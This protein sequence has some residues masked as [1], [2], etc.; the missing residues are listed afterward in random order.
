MRI[1]RPVN[2]L[3][4][5]SITP[6]HLRALYLSNI[7]KPNL[8]PQHRKAAT[9]NLRQNLNLPL[10]LLVISLNP[11]LNLTLITPVTNQTISI[12]NLMQLRARRLRV[13]R[14]RHE[15]LNR[16][17]YLALQN[18]LAEI[19]L[20][21]QGPPN[22]NPITSAALKRSHHPASSTESTGNVHLSLLKMR[23]DHLRK[24]NKVA[25]AL[26][27]ALLLVLKSPALERATGQIDEIDARFLELDAQVLTVL[28][29]CAAGLELDAVD[30]DAD[31][32]ARVGHAALYLGDDLEDYAAAVCKVAA[33]FVGAFVGC[34]GEELGQ[35]VAVGAVDLW[36][37]K[38]NR[39]LERLIDVPGHRRNQLDGTDMPSRPTP[40]RPS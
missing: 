24:L 12:A 23:P 14:Q 20:G 19:R 21:A 15:I 3:N 32:E 2:A 13:L 28:G 5:N 35:Q 31:D 10:R 37:V 8:R 11:P 9:I 40:P 38:P 18:F 39:R 25:F 33:V 26:L 34:Y 6:P 7:I 17:G 29:R 22:A 16:T 1:A 4:S 30:F 36:E 27:R